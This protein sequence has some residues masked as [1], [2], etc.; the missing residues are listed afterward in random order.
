MQSLE[1]EYFVQGLRVRYSGVGPALELENFSLRIWRF[2]EQFI[3]DHRDH[4]IIQQA[5]R[6]YP[7]LIPRMYTVCALRFASFSYAPT[8]GYMV[9]DLVSCLEEDLD[10]S[11]VATMRYWQENLPRPSFFGAL[12]ELWQA[13]DRFYAKLPRRQ[14]MEYPPNRYH[15]F[16]LVSLNDKDLLLQDSA[17]VRAQLPELLRAHHRQME[18][19]HAAVDRSQ[20]ESLH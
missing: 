14:V 15:A 6:R 12:L 18:L 19:I 5:V 16:V 1:K 3:R 4:T 7:D 11:V 9:K 13:I 17:R 8:L 10:A 2:V 20:V